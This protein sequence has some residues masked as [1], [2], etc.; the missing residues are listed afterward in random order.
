MPRKSPFKYHRFPRDVI[1]CAVRGYL[2][3]PLSYQDVV[4][5]LAER[6][7]AV[8]RSTV[9]RRCHLAVKCKNAGVSTQIGS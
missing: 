3:F 4:D 9:Y 8:D 1:H 5:L 7:V 6:G 2:H